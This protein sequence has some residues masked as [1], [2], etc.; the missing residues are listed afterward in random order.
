[1]RSLYCRLIKVERTSVGKK[2]GDGNQKIGNPH[3]KWAFSEIILAAQKYSEPITHRERRL[4][5]N[6]CLALAAHTA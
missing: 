5:P 4:I 1:M 6:M 3:L 2:T